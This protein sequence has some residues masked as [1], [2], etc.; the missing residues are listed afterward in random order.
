SRSGH[1]A[2]LRPRRAPGLAQ[3]LGHRDR[4]QRQ[5]PG[6]RAGVRLLASSA[7]TDSETEM[8]GLAP[9]ISH[10]RDGRDYASA[11][12]TASSYSR[13][14]RAI[15]S[16]A[17]TTLPMP[18]MPWPLPQISFQAFGLLRSPDASV[19]KLILVGSEV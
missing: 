12:S 19:P 6:D 1:Q 13:L 18:P 16:A 4:R 8:A 10:F 5:V 7:Y 11:G 2:R 15:S 17:G 14:K 9:A 3:D